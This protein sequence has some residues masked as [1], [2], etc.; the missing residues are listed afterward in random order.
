MR[1]ELHDTSGK[2]RD[3]VSDANPT[4][5]RDYLGMFKTHCA[6]EQSQY[7]FNHFVNWLKKN[8]SI[9]IRPYIAEAWIERVDM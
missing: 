3:I 9:E 2:V 6:V 4:A 7:E 5:M 1:Y 8:H